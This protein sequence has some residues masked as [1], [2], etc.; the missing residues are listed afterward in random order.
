MTKETSLQE[1]LAILRRH[2][3]L[4]IASVVLCAGCVLVVSILQEAHY[5]A[6]STV[7]FTPTGIDRAPDLVREQETL[8]GVIT[9]QDVLERAIPESGYTSVDELERNVTVTPVPE[10]NLLRISVADSTATGAATATNAVT[11][12]FI[13]W[14]TQRDR[15]LTQ[16]RVS[17]LEQQLASLAGRSTPA[18]IAAASALQTQLAEARAQLDVPTPELTLLQSAGIPAEPFSPRIVRN[19]IIGAFAGLLVGIILAVARDRLDRRLR[20][21]EEIEEIYGAPTLGV[22]P[23]V[24]GASRGN[25][26]VALGDYSG[27]SPVSEAYRSIRTN[28]MLFHIDQAEPRVIVVSSAVAEEGKS[29]CAA[30]L[31]TALAAAG[32][33]VLAVSADVHAPTLHEYFNF[34]AANGTPAEDGDRVARP[35]SERSVQPREAVLHERRGGGAMTRPRVEGRSDLEVRPVSSGALGMIEVLAGEASLAEAAREF[36]MNGVA[37]NAGS[38]WLLANNRRF[39]DPAV[40]FQSGAMQRL[41]DEARKRFDVVI[42]DSPPLLGRGESSILAHL[43]DS[44][45]LVARFGRLTRD[46]ALRAKRLMSASQLEPVGLVVTGRPEHEGLSEDMYAYGR[47]YRKARRGRGRRRNSR[48]RSA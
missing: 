28:L 46:R 40:L 3:V 16:A 48:T 34:E 5:R 8:A 17:S 27:S 42:I 11:S 20:R 43:G 36:P 30:N 29:A 25:R 22:V 19:T 23:F 9:T 14:Q 31:A 39:F 38:L 15:Q 10:A 32:K 35:E 47:D 4:V 37:K 13:E 7:L 33:L 26:P 21:V 12:A 24:E 2:A 44:L 41:L 45:V 18:D 6:T 1:Y